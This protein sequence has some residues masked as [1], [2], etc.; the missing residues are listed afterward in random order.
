MA[1]YLRPRRGKKATAEAQLTSSAPLKR[2]EVFFEVPDS[3]VG[4]GL[5]RIKM[6][7]GSTAYASLP[8]FL[9]QLNPDT[10]LVGFT[11]S[12]TGSEDLSTN[13]TYASAIV[14]SAN[15]K[16]IFTNLKQLLLNHNVQ[17]TKLN[18]DLVRMKS[19]VGMIIISTTLDTE[20]KVKAIYGGEHWVLIEGRM[21]LGVSAGHAVNSTGGSETHILSVEN[22]PSHAHGIPALSGTAVGGNHTH[23]LTSDSAGYGGINNNVTTEN[24]GTYSYPNGVRAIKI[25]NSGD[26][27]LGVATYASTT[28]A[29]GSGTAFD[30]MPPYKT[31]YMWERTA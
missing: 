25:A 28:G 7:D 14:P 27:T 23:G 21:L 20:D 31:V 6:G 18:N 9:E 8:T 24:T 15:L 2:G 1:S 19:H 10:A 11:N 22:L 30:T 29:T 4:T 3:G 5:G 16:T 12:T 17:L 26:L 13:A